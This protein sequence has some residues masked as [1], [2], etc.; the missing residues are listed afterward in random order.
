MPSDKKL[1]YQDL[2]KQITELKA[3]NEFLLKSKDSKIKN[4]PQLQSEK[5]LKIEL[6]QSLD[7]LNKSEKR[8]QDVFQSMTDMLS[9]VELIYDNDGKP[10]D[11]YYREV[12]PAFEKLVG[13]TKEQLI[14]KSLFSIF[15]I[16]ED[17]WIEMINGVASTGKTVNLEEYGEELD[18]Y[19][20]LLSWKVGENKVA[21]I[22]TDITPQKKIEKDKAKTKLR[23][24]K[25]INE[26]NQSQKLA[27]IGSWTLNSTTEIQ[28]WSDEMF[29]IWGFDAEKGT[30][31]YD[32][33]VKRIHIDDLDLYRSAVNKA[34]NQGT[35]YTIEFR[36]CIPNEETKT[37]KSI[38]QSVIEL[39]DSA[40]RLHGINQDITKQK[41]FEKE[42]VAHER[43]K[44][45]GEMSASI[46]HDFNNSLQQMSGNLEI[47]VLR[48]NLSETALERIISIR[49]I[50]DD[51]TGRV[52]ALQ[53]FGDTKHYSNKAELINLNT[54]I[55]ESLTESRP[56][57]KDQMEKEGLRIN[58]TTHF[59]AIPDSK[60]DRGEIKSVVYNIIRN[61]IEA[62]PKGGD[63]II[64][65]GRKAEGI[66][67]T[68]TDT[69]IGMD[70]ET[71][72]KVFQPFYSTKG[73]EVGRGLGL[74]GAYRVIKKHKGT[75][76]VKFSEL[77]KGTTIEIVCP[78]GPKSE[79]KGI[80]DH[81]PESKVKNAFRALWVDDDTTIRENSSELLELIGHKCDHVNSG[82]GALDYLNKNTCDIVFTDIG[83][84]DMNGWQ[85][86]DAI[87]NTFGSHIKIV[88]VTGW[89]VDEKTKNDHHV[90]FVL[91]KPFTMEALEK[92]LSTIAL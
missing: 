48:H 74:S 90:N 16:I 25:I 78:I 70:E 68:F 52:S 26:S 21:I 91:Q 10:V 83:M 18:K 11:Y 23:L 76:A 2:E 47:L 43:L 29:N 75:I 41:L 86:A 61:C 31:N 82:K 20:K 17:S 1:T 15:N 38:C 49:S 62:M 57:W 53:H 24:D 22:F 19:Y 6:K 14:N 13:K 44:A 12:N 65:T 4:R 59:E 88:A 51:V 30:P 64:K 5:S 35:P 63:I 42:L 40:V 71:K 27:N 77:G 55:S 32:A 39:T 80:S 54:I 9:I 69:G 66:F 87:R 45:T 79:K 50:I 33:V 56:L 72:L 34:I 36:I 67:V 84:P 28:E 3:Q 7:A 85:L 73:F 58:I 8:Y 92:I 89:E 46:A 60:C 81:E 37:I